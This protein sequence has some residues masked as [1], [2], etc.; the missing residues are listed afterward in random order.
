MIFKTIGGIVVAELLA[1]PIAM[2]ISKLLNADENANDTKPKKESKKICHQPA[3][4]EL[5]Y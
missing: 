5:L 2:K 4:A 1:I 3:E